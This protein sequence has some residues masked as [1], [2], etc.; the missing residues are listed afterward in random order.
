MSM[1]YTQ[2]KL[3][4][5]V[6]MLIGTGSLQERLDYVR[7]YLAPLAYPFPG[8]PSLRS[9]LETVRERLLT[10]L[11]DDEGEKVAQEIMLL[12]LEAT[13]L[14]PMPVGVSDAL[15]RTQL[16]A[17]RDAL[18]AAHDHAVERLS[19]THAELRDHDTPATL[20]QCHAAIGD[21]ADTL[22]PLIGHEAASRFAASW[23]ACEVAESRV[24]H[25]NATLSSRSV[26]DATDVTLRD[27]L[28][29]EAEAL[30][31]VFSR[32]QTIVF[33]AVVEAR[34]RDGNRRELL[35]SSSDLKG[36]LHFSEEEIRQILAPL[37]QRDPDPSGTATRRRRRT[38]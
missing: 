6:N 20:A 7:A 9:R 10:T 27:D 14:D 33:A 38:S 18:W 1:H 12:L 26:L 16:G 23:H 13:S 21:Y 32:E 19:V 35:G 29:R 28:T 11:S 36:S 22:E 3:W 25:L 2:Q 37:E 4:E 5:A 15:T 24:D 17:D 8:W 34:K 31:K 30:A